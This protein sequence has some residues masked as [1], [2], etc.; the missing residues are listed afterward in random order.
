MIT[1]EEVLAA[2][3]AMI[4]YGAQTPWWTH[5]SEHLHSTGELKMKVGPSKDK[6]REVTSPGLPCDPR[7]GML[8]Q[9]DKPEEFLEGAKRA[10]IEGRYGRHGIYCFMEAHHQNMRTPLDNW[11]AYNDR[12]DEKLKGDK[13]KRNRIK[14]GLCPYC[15][16]MM[17]R[18][19][20]KTIWRCSECGVAYTD[21]LKKQL[22][23]E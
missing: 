5:N 20:Q 23:G 1:F 19:G 10:A 15:E 6:M 17:T 11:D 18:Q 4:F 21:E 8:M 13:I 22:Q 16:R 14:Q 2:K 7:G 9:T 12:L 3:P